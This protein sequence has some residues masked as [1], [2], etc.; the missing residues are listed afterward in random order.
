MYYRAAEFDLN[1]MISNPSQY[2][3][4]MENLK[5]SGYSDKDIKILSIGNRIAIEVK[6]NLGVFITEYDNIHGNIKI[7]QDNNSSYT[8]VLNDDKI[9][10]NFNEQDILVLVFF[11]KTH[12]K[13]VPEVLKYL[14]A[15]Q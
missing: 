12:Q 14:A 5:K 3:K 4:E 7:Y 11:H 9:K 10:S 15:F 13:N 8:V 2:N 6:R 1:E